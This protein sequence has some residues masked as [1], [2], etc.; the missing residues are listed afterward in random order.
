MKAR[1]P[2][3]V[4]ALEKLRVFEPKKVLAAV[5]A[6]NSHL[7]LVLES[8]PAVADVEN[9]ITEYNILKKKEWVSAQQNCPVKFWEEVLTDDESTDSSIS[10]FSNILKFALAALSLPFS[11]ASVER[12]FSVMGLVETKLRDRLF[13]KTVDAVMLV[14][15]MLLWRNENCVTFTPMDSMLE[16]F[17]LSMYNFEAPQSLNEDLIV[18]GEE[19][20]DGVHAEALSAVGEAFIELDENETLSC[21]SL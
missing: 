8:L 13:L 9:A 4:S 5:H 11:N 18:I 7:R 20:D 1:L 16:K 12:A 2:S 15:L 14:H 3:S 17:N 21:I 19:N 10:R 6:S